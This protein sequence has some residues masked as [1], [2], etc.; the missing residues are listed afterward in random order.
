MPLRSTDLVGRDF[1]PAGPLTVT[2]RSV[3]EFASAIGTPYRAG[4]AVPPT[5]PIVLVFEAMQTLMEEAGL[6]LPRIVHGEQ[7]FTY[8]RPIAVGDELTATIGVTGL[9]SLGGAEVI[10][11][12][13]RVT[14]AAGDPVCVARATLVHGGVD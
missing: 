3:A 6:D 4:D 1:P 11:T 7:R 2:E 9:R 12:E 14:G 8:E 10:T 13:S 5:Y